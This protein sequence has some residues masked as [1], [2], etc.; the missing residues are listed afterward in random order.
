MNLQ[1]SLQL[2]SKADLAKLIAKE[3]KVVPETDHLN[4]LWVVVSRTLHKGINV[5]KENIIEY[6]LT[7]VRYDNLKD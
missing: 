2:N 6:Y 4:E 1:L 3:L 5:T 7:C